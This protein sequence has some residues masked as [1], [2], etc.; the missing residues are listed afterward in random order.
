VLFRPQKIGVFEPGLGIWISGELLGLFR[1][2]F[3][4]FFT[5][6][7]SAPHDC[8]VRCNLL[9]SLQPGGNDNLLF[10]Y[11]KVATLLPILYAPHISYNII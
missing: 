1:L 10:N 9:F 4:L 7:V 11:S 6:R 2:S 3:P 5:K 8:N